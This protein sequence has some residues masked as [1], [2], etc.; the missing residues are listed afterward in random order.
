M[1]HN[2]T[3]TVD[4]LI[5]CKRHELKS[6]NSHDG[7]VHQNYAVQ[8]E[9][10]AKE[11]TEL[12]SNFPKENHTGFKKICLNLQRKTTEDCCAYSTEQSETI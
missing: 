12:Q 9:L 1:G 2:Q 6:N 7:Q 11:G 10:Q 8:T 5:N 3:L 4:V